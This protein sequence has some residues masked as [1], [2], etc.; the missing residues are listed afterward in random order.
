MEAIVGLVIVWAA[1]YAIVRATQ[2]GWAASKRAYRKRADAWAQSHPAVEPMPLAAKLATG[3]GTVLTGGVQTARGFL[4]GWRQGWPEGRAKGEAWAQRRA[5]AARAAM[6]EQTTGPIPHIEPAQARADS[7][8]SRIANPEPVRAAE[9]THDGPDP[10]QPAGPDPVQDVPRD[11]GTRSGTVP[12]DTYPGPPAT[13]TTNPTPKEGH[14]PM[15]ITTMSGGE[16]LNMDQLLAELDS[17]AKEASAELEDAQADKRRAT[18]EQARYD[19]M[20]SSLKVLDLD[21]QTLSDVA[22]L[23]DAAAARRQAAEARAAAADA[24]LAQ[25]E[26]TIKGV[27]SR[28]GLMQEAHQNTPHPAEKAFYQPA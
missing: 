26:A 13:E 8:D 15:P 5:E 23:A 2:G 24:T 22:A 17:I 20:V 12:Q 28:H 19:A 4:A 11:T 25:A 6:A 18:A 7:P 16:V 3:V 9:H 21:S 27:Q 1:A 10:V 14:H